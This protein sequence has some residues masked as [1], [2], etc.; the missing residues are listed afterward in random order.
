MNILILTTHLNFGGIASYVL[1]LAGELKKNGH[2]VFVG[3]SGGD[4]ENELLNLG[5]V[6]LGLNIRTKSELSPKILFSFFKLKKFIRENN[7]QLIHAQTRVT[8][9]LAFLLKKSL[10][11]SYLTTCHG[12]FKARFGRRVFGCWGE[13]VIAISEAVKRHLTDD[14]MVSADRVRL[15]YNGI[16]I[17]PR[18]EFRQAELRNKLG[19]KDG[20]VVGIVARL[21]P[22][23]GHKYLIEAMRYVIN[24]KPQAQLLIVGDGPSQEAL[25]ALVEK[26]NLKESIIFIK[27]R[28]NLEEL[29]ALMD[30]YVSPSV[31]EGLGLAI[32]EAQANY[33]P[34]VAFATGG[35]KDIIRDEI[36]GLLVRP[37]AVKELADAILK[38]ILDDE[39]ARRLK[40][41]AYNFVA[42]NFSVERM[43]ENTLSVYREVL[44]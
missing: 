17:G 4:L 32:L 42:E 16:R 13:K 20:P 10:G 41:E 34:V 25:L 21:S 19:L 12:Y 29:F 31:Q 38:L 9:V 23:K 33:V 3:S 22:V 5:I 8:Q 27:P 36:N 14:F 26:L 6:H 40:K 37:F 39:L 43:A 35:I 30:V 2:N 28:K 18:R 7:I 11:I 44:K 1:N 15:V 24:S